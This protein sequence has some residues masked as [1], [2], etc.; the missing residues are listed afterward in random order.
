MQLDLFIDSSEAN[1]ITAG[2]PVHGSPQDRGSADKYYGRPF[3]P[4][5]WPEGTLKGM[6]VERQDMTPAEIVEYVYGYSNEEDTKDW[7]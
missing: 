6:R 3:D 1:I 7:G 2:L 4:H 5:F